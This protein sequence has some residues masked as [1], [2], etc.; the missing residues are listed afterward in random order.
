MSIQP[1]LRK[2]RTCCILGARERAQYNKSQ[3]RSPIIDGGMAIGVE[4]VVAAGWCRLALVPARLATL[5][6]GI[7]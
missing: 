5:I 4:A 1:P 6:T 3:G 7:K 2:S